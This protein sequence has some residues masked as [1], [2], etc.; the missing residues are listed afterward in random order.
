MARKKKIN[1]NKYLGGLT[2]SELMTIGTARELPEIEARYNEVKAERETQIVILVERANLTPKEQAA[3]R[4]LEFRFNQ[5]Q[6]QLE[7]AQAS[8]EYVN[9]HI[10][11]KLGG[12]D[13]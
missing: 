2:A 5:L 9:K 8:A 11:V 13:L 4:A 3:W 12:S 1:P 6:S 7:H 10:D